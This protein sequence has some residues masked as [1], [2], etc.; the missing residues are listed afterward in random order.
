MKGPNDRV[1]SGSVGV[2]SSP[3]PVWALALT[4]SLWSCAAHAPV[5]ANAPPPE[6]SEHQVDAATAAVL[7]RSGIGARQLRCNSRALYGVNLMSLARDAVST[8]ATQ[9][10]VQPDPEGAHEAARTVLGYMVRANFVEHRP[11]NLGAIEV[12]GYRVKD[13]AGE[14]PLVLFRSGVL[15]D[16]GEPE[17]CLHSLIG[18]ADVEHVVNLYAGSFPFYD[19]IDA[20]AAVIRAHG[21]THHSEPRTGRSWRNLIEE[22]AE[23]A[24]NREQAMRAVARLIREQVLLPGGEVARGNVLLHCGGG[25]H[26]TGMVYG[27]IRR[28]INGDDMSVVEDD[29]KQHVAYQ[30]AETPGGYESLNVRF[31]REFDCRLLQT[32]EAALERG[33]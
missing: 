12:R 19:F 7:E 9:W 27:I 26:R 15:V 33:D 23:Y 13:E 2:W 10:E 29:Y 11:H 28:C 24:H 16:V 1:R 14:R 30:D 5:E 8:V 18:E 31:I 20:E 25:M 4:L 32:E 17:S 22:P 21:G 3:S 6:S